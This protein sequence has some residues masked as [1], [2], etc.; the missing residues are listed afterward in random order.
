MPFHFPYGFPIQDI[1]KLIKS[2]Y[3]NNYVGSLTAVERKEKV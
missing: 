1:N 3:K 2:E